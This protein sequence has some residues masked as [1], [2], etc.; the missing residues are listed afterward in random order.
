VAGVCPLERKPQNIFYKEKG[1]LTRL[2]KN[3]PIFTRRQQMT[4]LCRI[5]NGFYLVDRDNFIQTNKIL[6]EPIG[7]VEMNPIESINI[8]HEIDYFLAQL[9][10]E[11]YNL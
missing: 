9:A 2:F 11:K 1:V 7:F 5:S 10:S 6:I 8:D 3:A 4:E